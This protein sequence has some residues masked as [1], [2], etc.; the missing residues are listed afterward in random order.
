MY[1]NVFTWNEEIYEETPDVSAGYDVFCFALL[2]HTSNRIVPRLQER[3]QDTAD[4]VTIEISLK[5]R[6]FMYIRVVCTT[7]Y[8]TALFF[9]K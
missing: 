1:I 7:L 8:Q 4:R 5:P 2:I 3:L 9:F 6:N